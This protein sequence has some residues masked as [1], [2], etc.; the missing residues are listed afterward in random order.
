[1]TYSN[2]YERVERFKVSFNK[3]LNITLGVLFVLFFLYLVAM[4]LYLHNNSLECRG[5]LHSMKLYESFGT[6][7]YGGNLD[8]YYVNDDKTI[9]LESNRYWF[10]RFPSA[11]AI[12]RNMKQVNPAVSDNTAEPQAG[13]MFYYYITK[14]E[15]QRIQHDMKHSKA[16]PIHVTPIFACATNDKAGSL[17]YWVSLVGRINSSWITLVGYFTILFI[18][19]FLGAPQYVKVRNIY[20]W[21]LAGLFPL[22]LFF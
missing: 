2:Y 22:I 5:E 20:Y 12:Y 4:P 9:V 8:Y 3:W 11:Y 17:G 13:D 21:L 16:L 19:I 14:N 15:F 18:T 1:M 10:F 6:L 7:R